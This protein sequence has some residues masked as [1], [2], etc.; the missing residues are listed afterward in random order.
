[1]PPL[2]V[3]LKLLSMI[4]LMMMSQVWEVLGDAA[5]PLLPWGTSQG[6]ATI[7]GDD[8]SS[9]GVE[10][11]ASLTGIGITKYFSTTNGIIVFDTAFRG[12]SS[13]NPLTSIIQPLIAPLWTDLAGPSYYRCRFPS[14]AEFASLW[15]ATKSY[16]PTAYQSQ[17]PRALLVVTFNT[18]EYSV[19]TVFQLFQTNVMWFG[20]VVQVVNRYVRLDTFSS[21]IPRVGYCTGPYACTEFANSGT[22]QAISY[23]TTT[24][25]PAGTRGIYSFEMPLPWHIY[26]AKTN[27]PRL[28]QSR[29]PSYFR[30]SLTQSPSLSQP[31]SIT[32]N[33]ETA[34]LSVTD[35]Q[36]SSYSDEPSLTY[37]PSP[38]TPSTTSTQSR[39]TV[40]SL[41]AQQSASESSTPATSRSSSLEI[42]H[43]VVLTPS[44]STNVSVS[45]TQTR[46]ST[47][48][49]SKSLSESVSPSSTDSGSVSLEPCNVSRCFLIT[50]SSGGGISGVSTVTVA[51]SHVGDFAASAIEGTDLRQWI[52]DGS[53]G[54]GGELRLGV[55]CGNNLIHTYNGSEL[56]ADS[57]QL[58]LSESTAAHIALSAETLNLKNLGQLRPRADIRLST[59]QDAGMRGIRDAASDFMYWFR[60][61]TL[62]VSLQLQCGTPLALRTTTPQHDE[63]AHRIVEIQVPLTPISLPLEDIS[64]TVVFVA[65]WL[66]MVGSVAAAVSIS[67]VATWRRLMLCTTTDAPSGGLL[68]LSVPVSGDDDRNSSAVG[69]VVGNTAVLVAMFGVLLMVGVMRRRGQMRLVTSPAAENA[70]CR[71]ALGES[72]LHAALPGSL[73]PSWI[74]LLPAMIAGA[75][76]IFAKAS[77]GMVAA[78]VVALVWLLAGILPLSIFA[79]RGPLQLFG[80]TLSEISV[81]ESESWKTKLIAKRGEWIA[82]PDA[83]QPSYGSEFLSNMLRCVLLES[84]AVWYV[85]LDIGSCV[86]DILLSA[87]SPVVSV[88]TCRGLAAAATAN[89]AVMLVV[90]LVF[91]PYLTWL[92]NG[93]SCLL[94]AL[95]VVGRIIR[96]VLLLNPDG[97]RDPTSLLNAA[98]VIDIITSVAGLMMMMHS[99]W[100]CVHFSP[101]RAPPPPTAV[102]KE[103]AVDDVSLGAESEPPPTPPP[104]DDDDDIDLDV[105][106]PH[107]TKLTRSMNGL[108]FGLALDEESDDEDKGEFARFYGLV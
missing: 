43:S 40:A 16:V 62:H 38:R 91:R 55:H 39:I 31:S 11:L 28:T 101:Q 74:M 9:Q 88:A 34:D 93:L 83:L 94:L 8:L 42:T 60:G 44:H 68:R 84:G 33:S 79:I 82:R 10:S 104:E 100:R 53:S 77:G 30:P 90:C 36:S 51:P 75:V 26:V 41:S 97:S 21:H 3:R 61:H 107:E 106:K 59:A 18:S 48:S 85:M 105:E 46:S 65:Q 108:A 63:Q 54:S 56:S 87:V 6:D 99:L 47:P 72:V 1:M 45:Q 37:S 103:V 89:T 4:M 81:A 86:A 7:S 23:T 66:D 73:I 52:V 2:P 76:W 20:S 57:T 13:G 64:A 69:A 22:A 80:L 15:T 102:L 24:Q 12:Y 70:E 17:T 67:R 58:W 98:Y 35:T 27:T 92:Q 19:P 32:I 25:N 49:A 50:P 29:S 14:D 71:R 5:T 96:L 78:G 95:N